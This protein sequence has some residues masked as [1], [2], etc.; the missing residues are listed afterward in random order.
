MPAKAKPTRRCHWVPQAYL[1]GFAA[2]DRKPPRIWRFSKEGGDP[3]LKRIDKVVVRNHLYVVSDDEGKRDD[4]Q[5]RRF[6]SLEELFGNPVWK[7]L[8]TGYVDLSDRAIRK[9]LSLLAA[10]TF[11]RHPAHLEL[12]KH[13]HRTFVDAYSGPSGPPSVVEIGGRRIEVDLAS[14]PSYANASEDDLKRNWFDI[15]NSCVDIA[16]MFMDM[17]W[18]MLVADQPTFITSDRP[19]TMV[20]PDLQFRGIKDPKTMVMFP[21]SPTRILNMDYMYNEPSNQYYAVHDRGACANLLVWREA[22][23]FMFLSRN[24]DEV[25][26]E[27]ASL[28]DE[29]NDGNAV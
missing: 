12:V 5:E 10:T 18:S 15:M 7:E 21:I 25:C 16:E 26:Q 8:Q 22:T 13:V 17:R 2:D 11:V 28:A 19:V 1:K 24:P 4:A 6:A 9:M 23:E 29:F 14:W 27:L 3:E 20:H